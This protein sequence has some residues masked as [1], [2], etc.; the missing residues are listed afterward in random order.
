MGEGEGAGVNPG[1]AGDPGRIEA[2]RDER[3]V[4]R[5]GDPRRPSEGEV[6]DHER[7]HLP[8][9]NWCYHC[10]GGKGRDLDHRRAVEEERG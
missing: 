3:K 8:Y 4:V 5:L 9:R 7:T 6:Q 2:E 1:G 10:V